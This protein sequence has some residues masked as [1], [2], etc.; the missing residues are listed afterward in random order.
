MDDDYIARARVDARRHPHP[1]S[2]RERRL[3]RGSAD[4]DLGQ[5]EIPPVHVGPDILRQAMARVS[6]VSSDT[7]AGGS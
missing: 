7:T 3:H 4:D 2:D 1:S 5:L 6:N